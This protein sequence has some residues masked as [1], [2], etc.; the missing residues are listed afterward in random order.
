MAYRK[1][2]SQC[3]LVCFLLLL[4]FCLR[5]LM[6]TLKI[7]LNIA[8]VGAQAAKQVSARGQEAHSTSGA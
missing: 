7:E 4:H 3:I 2:G 1:G 8:F 5:V 6:P